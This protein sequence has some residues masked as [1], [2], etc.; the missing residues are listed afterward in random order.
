MSPALASSR[1]ELVRSWRA[2][3]GRLE[4]QMNPHSFETW[5]RGTEPL[6]LDGRQLIIE[7]RHGVS[8]EWLNGR[9]SCII[10]RAVGAIF[11][12]DVRASFVPRSL[13]PVAAPVSLSQM[14]SLAID[15]T[16][17]APDAPVAAPAGVLG[18]LNHH[19]TF[20]RYLRATGNQVALEACLALVGPEPQPASPVVMFGAPGLGK[21]HLLHALAARAHSQG[22]PV[23]C[24]GAEEFTNRYQ[25]ALRSKQVE[26][27]QEA[28]RS[29]RL[30][31]VDD[32][33]YL[34]GRP[35]TI[36]EF[37]HT[38]DAITN[39]GGVV[40]CASERDPAGLDLPPRL[41]SR[42]KAGV[43]AMMEPLASIDRRAYVNAR[44]REHRLSLPA[45]AIDRVAA[46]E[47][48]SIRVL[49]GAVNT[50]LMLQRTGQMDPASLDAH[51]VRFCGAAAAAP[52]ALDQHGLIEAVAAHFAVT[53]EEL[54][55]RTRRRPV[56]EARAVAMAA[57]I[58]RG[59][60]LSQVGVLFS[61]RDR[62]TVK[63]A[64]DRGRELLE[65]DPVLRARLVG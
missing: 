19:Y 18:A 30:L 16:P 9:L 50:A 5:L 37:V 63:E 15:G 38:I 44:A 52:A 36:D 8:C 21:T 60:S 20:D 61:N 49:Q 57:L 11:G 12:E 24:L 26:A 34:P 43:L 27:F 28:V 33:Q 41:V 64:S 29:V 1:V 56:T 45:W 31:V 47:V 13:T 35:A 62:S 4:L 46:C 6:R 23:A 48:P 14:P 65:S 59:Q 54:I 32:L 51:L 42:L 22:W 7:A 17:A 3:L 55:G 58:E 39:A 2:V 53:F 25:A 40:A 10:D